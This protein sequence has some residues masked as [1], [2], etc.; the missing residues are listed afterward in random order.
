MAYRRLDAA[1]MKLPP[2][3]ELQAV[4]DVWWREDRPPQEVTALAD[5]LGGRLRTG[6]SIGAS[7][8]QIIQ[9]GDLLRACR[10]AMRATGPAMQ[11]PTR[12]V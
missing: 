8:R 11:T 6:A 7:H 5:Q 9:H 2:L 4:P 3:P 12:W 1:I 10:Q